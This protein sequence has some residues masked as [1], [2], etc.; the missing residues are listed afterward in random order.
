MKQADKIVLFFQEDVVLVFTQAKR[1]PLLTGT[2]VHYK[3]L[4]SVQHR[5]G[6]LIFR[7]NQFRVSAKKKRGEK[8]IQF[9]SHSWRI[10]SHLFV[11]GLYVRLA[12]ADGG[13]GDL[14]PVFWQTSMTASSLRTGHISPLSR[15]DIKSAASRWGRWKRKRH[16]MSSTEYSTDVDA[17]KGKKGLSPDQVSHSLSS[18]SQQNQASNQTTPHLVLVVAK[19][20]RGFI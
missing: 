3:W 6:Q 8:K 15:G 13:S 16:K 10:Q 19:N 7:R 2:G 4:I 12:A 5:W 18:T 1:H 14:L 11:G 20:K 9:I 17:V